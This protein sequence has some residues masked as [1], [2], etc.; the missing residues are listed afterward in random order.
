[1]IT[2]FTFYL[3]ESNIL[4]YIFDQRDL[5]FGIAFALNDSILYHSNKL[6]EL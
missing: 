2:V 1:M 3:F 6:I 4:N 5:T